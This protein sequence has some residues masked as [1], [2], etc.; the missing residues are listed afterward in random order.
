MECVE[1]TAGRLHLRPWEPGDAEAV[2]AACQDPLIQRCTRLPSPYTVDDAR[3][4]VGE[5]SPAAWEAGTD[6][7]FAVL[8]ATTAGLLGSVGLHRIDVL[9]GVAEIGYW[10][11]AEARGHG[12][13]TQAVRAVC[14]WA[15]GG[16]YGGPFDGAGLARID[17]YAKVGN[18]ASRRVAE[19]VGFVVEGV[20]RSRLRDGAG[21]SD[22]WIAG[23]LPEALGL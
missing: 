8:D 22:A 9:D 17:W 14:R 19:K 21:R 23:L 12:V 4:W 7:S 13:T 16:P 18:W 1:I 2:F 6:A 3:E 20:L 15:F 10:C 11:A 5:R